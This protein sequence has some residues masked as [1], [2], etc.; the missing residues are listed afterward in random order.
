MTPAAALETTAF[1]AGRARARRRARSRLEAVQGYLYMSPWLIGFFVWTLGPMIFSAGLAFFEWEIV[2]PP[3]FV[4]FGHFRELAQDRLFYKSLFNT[5]YYSFVRVP[6]Q[7]VVSLTV[8]FALNTGLSGIRFYRTI[9]YL[10]SV[11]PMVAI[12]IL[13][14]WV[15]NPELGLVNALLRSLGLSPQLWMMDP[16][17]VKPVFIFVSLWAIGDQFVIFLAGL[18]GI[19]IPLK[20]A[21]AIDGA[22]S[23][24]SLLHI[25]IPVL[26]PVIFFNLVV[27][28]IHSFLVFTLAYIAS[29]GGPNY[30]SLFY[31]LYLY[32][33]AFE[34]MR[35]G[36]AA[37]LAWILFV[38]IGLLTLLQL[39][40][41][42][43]WVYYEAPIQR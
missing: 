7:L 14:V 6:L 4:G 43:R 42:S 10:P 22:T 15:F 20:E 25:T 39:N 1:E 40:L 28:V 18:Q 2:T 41:A 12:A 29:N 17:L 13:W 9:F 19:P 35:M 8:A 16:K 34:F 23:W 36:Y 3:Q 26:S 21:A 31:V 30:A 37:L 33:N 32:R 11:I 5:A 27:G 38:I 24:Q